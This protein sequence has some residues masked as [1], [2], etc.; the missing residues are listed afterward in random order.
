[1]TVR[2]AAATAAVLAVLAGCTTT[3]TTDVPTDRFVESTLSQ[4]GI[5]PTGRV[6]SPQAVIPDETPDDEEDQPSAALPDAAAG[7]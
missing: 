4:Y 7:A 3:P 1:M 5:G 6:A 2:N